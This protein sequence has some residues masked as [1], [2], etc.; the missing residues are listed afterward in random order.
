MRIY[1]FAT[2]NLKCMKTKKYDQSKDLE[3][4]IIVRIGKDEIQDYV[5]LHLGRELND[6]ELHRLQYWFEWN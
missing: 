2:I 1:R 6:V 5:D 4:P 3:E